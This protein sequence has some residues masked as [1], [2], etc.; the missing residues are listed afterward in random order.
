MN[1]ACLLPSLPCCGYLALWRAL[2][3]VCAAGERPWVRSDGH[4]ARGRTTSWE[5]GQITLKPNRGKFWRWHQEALM[6]MSPEEWAGALT[7][8]GAGTNDASAGLRRHDA[9]PSDGDGKSA[10]LIGFLNDLFDGKDE[11]TATNEYL[12]GGRR[13]ESLQKGL[14]VAWRKA[15]LAITFP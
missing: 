11:A 13:Y 8:G 7:S 10:R 1:P 5:G 12:P 14:A 3:C 15:G 4:R 2:G 6:A 9:L